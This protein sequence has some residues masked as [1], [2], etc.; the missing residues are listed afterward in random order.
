MDVEVL[1]VGAGVVGLAVASELSAQRAVVVVERNAAPGLE[2]SSR[3]SEV[4]HAGLYYPTDSLKAVCCVEGRVALYERCARLGIP[5]RK[6]GKLIVASDASEIGALEDIQARARANGA[7]VGEILDAAAVRHLEPRVRAVAALHSPETGIVDAHALVSSHQAE[8]ESNGG[9]VVL[10]TTI[11]GLSPRG[12]GW[13]VCTRT[14]EGERFDIE[15]GCVVNAAGLGADHVAGLAGID[16]DRAGYRQHPCKG[17]Y[18]AVAP[19][20]GRLCERLVYPVPVPGGLGTHVTVDLGGRFRL[21]PDVTYVEAPT[22]EVD[23]AKAGEFA[24]AVGRYLPEIRPEHLSPDFAGIRPKL[25][26]PGEGFRDFTIEEGS[27]LGAPGLV[28]LL[29]IESPGLTSASAIARR[30]AAL[31]AKIRS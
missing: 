30:V 23:P 22:Y 2:T 21:G 17:D 10:R 8:C 18:F 26:G 4:I 28:N 5:H 3:N 16:V 29:G 27:A 1:V 13:T 7:G 20:L 14:A 24:R 9:L 15:A 25:Q 11:L 12:S 31:V 6:L 19:G